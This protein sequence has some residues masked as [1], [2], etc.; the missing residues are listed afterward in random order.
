MFNTKRKLINLGS[1]NGISIYMHWTFPLGGIFV[2]FLYHAK[3]LEIFYICAANAI[4]VFMHELG[5]AGAAMLFGRKVMS[6]ELFGVGGLCRSE[7]PA[8]RAAAFVFA[9]AGLFVQS[10]VLTLALLYTNDNGWP[11]TVEGSSFAF[12][13]I[14]INGLLIFLNLIPYKKGSENF[15]S[16]G[17]ILWTLLMQVIRK[18]PYA[19]PDVSATFSPKISLLSRPGMV[20]KGFEVGIEIYNDNNTTMEH[21]VEALVTHVQLPRDEAL[22]MMLT[23]HKNG[24]LLIPVETY[25]QAQEIS[26]NIVDDAR[27]M[28]YPLLCRAVR[29]NQNG[30]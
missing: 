11:K 4:I 17:Y 20:P 16:D 28:G 1:L 6:I 7:T 3:G 9:A 29:A 8:T 22:A 25:E 24:G 15:G 5:H 19:Y 14:F 26:S 23:I 13:F 27:K 30:T 10:I 2:A 18:T 12:V 21:V